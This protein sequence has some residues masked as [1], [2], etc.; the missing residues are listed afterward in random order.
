MSSRLPSLLLVPLLLSVGCA[1]LNAPPQPARYTGPVVDLHTHVHFGEGYGQT[2]ASHPAG[3]QALLGLAAQAH[4]EKSGI[5]VMAPRGNL[6]ATRALNDKVIAAARAGNGRLFAIASVHPDDG[7]E[8]LTEMERL[9]AQDVRILKLHP[10]TQRFD[11]GSPAVDAVVQKAGELG[12]VLLFDGYSPFDA[13]QPGKFTLL[14]LKHPK[15]RIVLAHMGG[16]GFH[17]LALFGIL[18]QFPYY[19]RNLWFDLSATA[20]F[21][22]D[23]PYE[24]QLVWIARKIGTDRILFGSDWPVDTPAHAVEDCQ[25]L[26]FTEAEQREIFH[27]NA[28]RLLGM[29]PEP[30]R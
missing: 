4:V 13:G 14:A 22:V 19:Q 28:L 11:V 25:R 7:V 6:P 30:A 21:F 18:R 8:A 9:R 26:G 5:I 17:D 29:E 1:H 23:S 24:E 27:T 16:P 10:N 20:H 12:L 15:A 3:T 2:D